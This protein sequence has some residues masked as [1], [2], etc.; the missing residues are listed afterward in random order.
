MKRGKIF[1]ILYPFSRLFSVCK[2][3]TSVG[4][5]GAK[6]VSP[7]PL[8]SVGPDLVVLLVLEVIMNHAQYVIYCYK[9]CT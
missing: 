3:L 6:Y 9:Q 5:G 1:C 2:S 4:T 7:T 8:T